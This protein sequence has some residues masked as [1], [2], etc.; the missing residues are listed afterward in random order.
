MS[1]IKTF[2]I[3][4]KKDVD[5]KNLGVIWYMLQIFDVFRAQNRLGNGFSGIRLLMAS[6]DLYWRI[7]MK[8]L[9]LG[10]V[11][12]IIVGILLTGCDTP[13]SE[14]NRQYYYYDFFTIS[15]TDY[16]SITE[17]TTNTFDS[18]KSYRDELISKKIEPLFSGSD[19]TQQDLY[20]FMVARGAS[21]SEANGLIDFL[22][23]VGN[24]VV[25]FQHATDNNLRV[26]GYVERL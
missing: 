19:A 8:R 20:D 12:L 11:G 21:A 24:N 17:P 13:T 15:R 22:N 3:H 9:G 5:R 1:L 10:I 14:S 26:I 16:E 23:T 2:K 25:V 7:N 6:L 18:V 4:R